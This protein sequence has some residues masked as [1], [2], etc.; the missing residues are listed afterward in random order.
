[1]IFLQK[2]KTLII[3]RRS[4]VVVGFGLQLVTMAL[5]FVKQILFLPL[6]LKYFPQAEYA[7]WIVIQALMGWFYLFDP[8][9]S[10]YY[11]QKIGHAY[12]EDNRESIALLAGQLYGF[13]SLV[14]LLVLFFGCGMFLCW[15]SL[16]NLGLHTESISVHLS[17]GISVL[18]VGLFMYAQKY[19]IFN[20]SMHRSAF[21]SLCGVFANL[22]SIF[23]IFYFY[24]S[25]G[26]TAIALGN[27][28]F[29]LLVL[30][31]NKFLSVSVCRDL[32]ITLKAQSFCFRSL[33][34][35]GLGYVAGGRIFRIILV[36]VDSILVLRYFGQQSV[37]NYDVIKKIMTF[38][39]M[40]ADRLGQ[41]LLSPLSSLGAVS[42]RRFAVMAK[43]VN[44]LGGLSILSMAVACICLNSTII[45]IWVGPQFYWGS[46]FNGLIV[47]YLAFAA[48]L[49]W[50]LNIVMA[51]GGFKQIFW[52]YFL[53]A[54][55]VNS[56]RV[57]SGRSENLFS[58]MALQLLCVFISSGYIFWTQLRAKHA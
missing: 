3:S 40:L 11:K 10:D 52:A 27:L 51:S 45:D 36:S 4:N 39:T 26:V 55:V 43:K 17:F 23:V 15:S 56:A 53:L 7:S 33:R 6:Y 24:R 50:Q 13:Q 41:I 57:L 14:A 16:S 5:L 2:Y 34:Q 18:S 35:L 28:T 25:L 32:G 48:L 31:G 9:F 54:L 37:I 49:R 46:V 20:N 44:Y 29:T 8:G 47:G 58:F 30:I 1:M 38:G 42:K 21:V 12:G 22:M 19:L